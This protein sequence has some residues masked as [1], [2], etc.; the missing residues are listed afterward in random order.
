MC[1]WLCSLN[2]NRADVSVNEEEQM[3][4]E[5]GEYSAGLPWELEADYQIGCV[6]ESSVCIHADVIQRTKDMCRVT[7]PLAVVAH[8]YDGGQPTVMCADCIINTWAALAR[9]A[10][11]KE[12]EST[13]DPEIA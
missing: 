6:H 9:R 4:I 2:R 7:L 3:D 10:V 11:L 12:D 13:C 1:R 5:K 8:T